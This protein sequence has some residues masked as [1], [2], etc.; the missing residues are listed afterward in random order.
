MAN[1]YILNLYG[2]NIK[3]SID[4]NTPYIVD[5]EFIKRYRSIHKSMMLEY[6]ASIDEDFIYKRIGE[7][8]YSLSLI[9]VIFNDNQK[10]WNEQ[11]QR[12]KGN[13][14]GARNYLYKHGFT[15]NGIHYVE[16]Q[17]SSSKA[18]NGNNLF[19]REDLLKPMLQWCRIGINI[20][21]VLCD[22]AAFRAYESLT[23]SDINGKVKIL[24]ENILLVDDVKG[25]CKAKQS[26]TTRD[27]NNN[28]TV[29]KC[30]SV[31]ENNIFDGESLLD[32]RK[33]TGA[34]K[35]KGFILL[36]NHFIKTAAFNTKLQKYFKD[37][38]ITKLVD[39]FG[40]EHDAKDIMMITTPNSIKFFKFKDLVADGTRKGCWDYLMQHIEPKWGICKTEHRSKFTKDFS[41]TQQLS[42]QFINSMPLSK[43]EIEKIAKLEI[44]YTNLLKRD[45]E[46]FKE[47]A[48]LKNTSEHR[49]VLRMAEIN[50]AFQGTQYFKYFYNSQMKYRKEN[51]QQGKIRIKSSDNMIFLGNPLELLRWAA[52]KQELRNGN[53]HTGYQV[54]TKKY[55][56]GEYVAMFRSPHLAAGN[57]VYAKNVWLDEFRYFNLTKNIIII[58]SYDSDIYNRLQGADLDSDFAFVTNNSIIVDKAKECQK[59]LTP[60]NGVP[61]DKRL[62]KFNAKE[63][64]VVDK[65][66]SC[67]TIGI[68]C[69][70]GQILNVNPN[71]PAVLGRIV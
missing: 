70:T 50:P 3:I 10:R 68:I 58:N 45:F 47:Y 33:F 24:P 11:E 6:L 1:Y 16:F 40:V 64:S 44:D 15:V 4:N 23:S 14:K 37:N 20:E 35:G 48:G 42:Y 69:N 57:I 55:K 31:V 56:S 34:Y 62:R 65:K 17:R 61:A 18:R 29:N 22:V 21:N 67:N 38:N 8:I 36:R 71:P 63:K 13:F 26:I 28:F 39:M 27:E 59:W 12:Y 7:D 49:F 41:G 9:N 52:C 25:Y 43:K 2:N 32:E 46:A 66:I 53:V 30:S 60:V 51:L 54:Y 5:A 19:I